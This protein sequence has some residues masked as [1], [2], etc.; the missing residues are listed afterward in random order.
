MVT[1]IVKFDKQTKHFDT[2]FPIF[3]Q[4]K[5][6]P[7]ELYQETLEF[8]S[9]KTYQDLVIT[10]QE[11]RKFIILGLLTGFLFVIG[12]LF[13]FIFVVLLMILPQFA[14]ALSISVII[15]N[16][17]IFG[18]VLLLG[19]YAYQSLS[20]L[21][22]IKNEKY[23]QLQGE[24]YEDSV[25]K[26]KNY[27]VQIFFK[28]NFSNFP[29]EPTLEII[30]FDTD[31]STII[32]K[33]SY[34]G[35]SQVFDSTFPYHLENNGINQEDYDDILT[36]L[37]SQYPALLKRNWIVYSALGIATGTFTS[38]LLLMG[39]LA[40]DMFM[41]RIY[42]GIGLTAL[43]TLL[44]ILMMIGMAFFS[45]KMKN[46]RKRD[47]KRLTNVITSKSDQLFEHLNIKMELT[48]EKPVDSIFAYIPNPCL[49]FTTRIVHRKQIVE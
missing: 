17:F 13:S 10:S 40:L 19:F 44:V 11:A 31:T 18:I 27:D 49:K 8:F 26:Y 4:E 24:C 29:L 37:K 2:T 35:Y 23:K 22:K 12:I 9:K 47:Y 39:I 16:L 15:A 30:S 7:E 6:I 42:I 3:L 14:T 46:I 1:H 21:F 45:I 34:D 41:N 32:F 5:G 33:N 38:A 20:Q 25:S 28:M 48:N 36:I 43:W